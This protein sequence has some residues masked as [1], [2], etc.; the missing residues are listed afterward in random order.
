M[1]SGNKLSK[2]LF[3]APENS[4]RL[5]PAFMASTR[6][7]TAIHL[8]KNA[9]HTKLFLRAIRSF[10]Q[11]TNRPSPTLCP[12]RKGLDNIARISQIPPSATN[13][14]IVLLRRRWQ[15]H[16]I[17]A[18]TCGTPQPVT[19]RVVQ[20]EPGPIPTLITCRPRHRSRAWAPSAGRDI[21]GHNRN[22]RDISFLSNTRSFSIHAFGMTVR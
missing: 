6:A 15:P 5:L 16:S 22:I 1:P 20:I 14:D 7:H 9:L 3:R 4:G 13:R 21:S 17:M 10:R 12:G 11:T 19:T 18:V 2:P 8:Y